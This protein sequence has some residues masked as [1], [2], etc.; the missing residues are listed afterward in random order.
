MR[1]R[2]TA[3]LQWFTPVSVLFSILFLFLRIYEMVDTPS[4]SEKLKLE[5][6]GAL[7]D[8]FFAFKL[9]LIVFLVGGLTS[10]ISVRAAKIASTAI[11]STCFILSIA[12]IHYFAETN[13][14]LGTDLF[15]YEFDDVTTT[16][17]ASEGISMAPLLTMVAMVA[18]FVGLIVRTPWRSFK[19]KVTYVIMTV[20]ALMSFVP[21]R[22]EYSNFNHEMEYNI[23]ENK[24]RYFFTKSVEYV[25]DEK[26]GL[27]K[28]RFEKNSYPLLKR[29][30]SRDV[31]GEYLELGDS[32]PNICIV[33]VEG[34]GRDFSGVDAKW[35]G[36]TPFLDS[37]S[38]HSLSWSNALSNA[39][40]T[41][42]ALPS[43]IGSLPHGANGF[44]AYG[45]K[46]PNH[47]SLISVLK[48]NGY[49]A[50]FFYGG[51]ADF[52]QQDLFMQY[53]GVDVSMNES[54]FPPSYP[55][56]KNDLGYSWGYPDRQMFHA[57]LDVLAIRKKCPKVN[58]FLT[59]SN[60]EP[61][62]V[63]EEKFTTLA[64]EKIKL[65]KDSLKRS[66][67][68]EY[69]DIFS[70][71][72]YTD[73]ALRSFVRN[74]QKRP[75]FQNTIFV[76]TG[77]HRLIPFPQDTKLTRFR[78]PLMIYSPM[79]KGARAFESVI[80]HSDIFPS[81]IA[82]LSKKYTIKT[83]DALPLISNG[84]IMD[85]T[86][87]CDRTITLM[88]SKGSVS[89]FIDRGYYLSDGVLFR[90]QPGLEL[91]VVEDRERK[92]Q[93][94]T[95]QRR[96]F[97]LS[98]WVCENDQLDKVDRGDP[99]NVFQFSPSEQ[100]YLDKHEIADM[101]PEEIFDRAKDLGTHQQFRESRTLLRFV[102]NHKPN[103]HDARVLLG[104]TFA[105]NRQYDSARLILNEVLK[106]STYYEDT[107][108]ALSDIDFWTGKTE[109]AM[110]WAENGL[111]F[112][113]GSVD[114]RARQARGYWTRGNNAEAEKLLNAVLSEQP[115]H[116]LA[117]EIL[118]KLKV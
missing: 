39:G 5:S 25:K 82:L 31:L 106:R 11:F 83:P 10:L 3:F 46:M 19:P 60:H 109:E 77:D 53:Q 72:M 68:S 97:Q 90:L 94:L 37:L 40:R 63:P 62:A 86:F 26:L 92:R 24:A 50:N 104:R 8:M 71:L 14:L 41:F 112:H 76:I 57:A 20:I 47:Q 102:L 36:F 58:V 110:R 96:Q 87:R 65:E 79:L 30:D 17:S 54:N 45:N 69:K 81:L 52:D 49:E 16:V 42:G 22:A 117:N 29:F 56:N 13:V 85:T 15:G 32:M 66:L 33:I 84:L 78:V 113:P 70:C 38:T 55:R 114:L 105:W 18:I 108:N 23:V 91:S 59:L 6:I 9:I 21:V 51:N 98:K 95:E 35:G 43:V 48:E 93:M 61:F 89:D 34:L 107:Y 28:I 74:Y 115:D 1:Q 12:L 88:K 80:F 100:D 64:N 118:Q 7:Y 27:D 4:F 101:E 116:E 75:E 73:D 103:Y 67:L 44:M 99:L 111:Q 2:F